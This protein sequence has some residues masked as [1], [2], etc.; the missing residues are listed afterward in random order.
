MIKHENVDYYIFH[1][2][3][4]DPDTAMKHRKILR[5]NV[6]E[7]AG[8]KLYTLTYQQVLQDFGVRNWNGRIYSDSVVMRALDENPLIQHDLKNGTWTAEYGHPQIDK[9]QNALS[10]QM[11]INP[12]LAC[13]TINRYWRE[14]N[15]LMGE[16]T[17]LAGGW[18]DV[19]MER[20]LTNY[21]AMASSR[22][23]GGTDSSGNVLPGYTIVTFDT[24]IRPSH[25]TA[26]MVKNSAKVNEFN[27]PTGNTMSESVTVFDAVNNASFKNFL[28]SESTS[29]QKISIVCDAL[30]FDYDTMELTE[31]AI[32]MTRTDPTGKTKIVMPLNKLVGAEYWNLFRN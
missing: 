17:T 8:R 11:I 27:M 3:L 24:V 9:G 14:G 13:N 25:K 30:G 12:T 7:A 29:K 18:G 20:I 23:I 22:A 2:E 28:L 26:Y 4:V 6:V 1:N 31:N 19:L 15:F 32:T 5:E 10:R 16:C 21:P